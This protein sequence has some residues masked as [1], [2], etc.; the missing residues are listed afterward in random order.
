MLMGRFNERS[1]KDKELAK[2]PDCP[3]PSMA[4]NT[5]NPE[6]SSFFKQSIIL[7][8]SCEASVI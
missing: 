1:S 6:M 2:L 3:A 5:L 7:L 4:R 8:S